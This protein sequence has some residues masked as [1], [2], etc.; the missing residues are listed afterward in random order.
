M[1]ALLCIRLKP[2][3][4]FLSKLLPGQHGTIVRFR[5]ACEEGWDWYDVTYDHTPE[6]VHQCRRDGL[7]PARA[8][9]QPVY[10]APPFGGRPRGRFGG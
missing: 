10:S 7:T 3:R 5:H 2:F 6:L 9:H 4:R 8:N 1:K